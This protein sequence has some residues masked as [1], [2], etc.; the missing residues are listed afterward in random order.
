MKNLKYT[1]LAILSFLCLSLSAQNSSLM[2]QIKNMTG[3]TDPEKSVVLMKKIIKDNNLDAI[4]D[5]ETIDMLKGTVALTYLKKGEYTAFKRYINE[6][7]SKFNQTSF[8]N[9][10]ASTIVKDEKNTKL[11][12]QIAKETIDLYLSFKD[13]ST[14][15]PAGMEAADWKRFMNFAQYPYYDSYASALYANG[16]YKE[17]LT[18]QEKAFDRTPEEGMASSVERYAHLLALNGKADQAFKLLETLVKTGKS[19]AVMDA[20]LKELYAKKNN[21]TT[22]FETYFSKLQ[23]SVKSTVKA[24]LKTKMLNSVAPTFTL[25]DLNGKEIALGDLKGKVVVLDF[26]ATWCAPCIA[27]FPAMQKMVSKHKDVAFLFIAT[28]EKEEGALERVKSFIAKNKYNF[29]VLMDSEITGKPGAYQAL[30]A[31]KPSGIPAK[32]IIDKNGKLRFA[33]LGFSSDSELINE[34]EAMI[35]LAKD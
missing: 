29:H 3:E 6:M 16:K 22:S 20:Q 2:E 4:K 27:S 15:R 28:Q 9:M 35:E 13:D 33:T 17:A 21:S 34:L 30:S 23:T 25:K 26:W 31:Y 10:A 18:Y 19:T 5:E 14:A 24:E 11:A 8:L 32:Y 1:L 12:E 7:T